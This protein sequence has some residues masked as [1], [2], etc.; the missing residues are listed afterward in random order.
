MHEREAKQTTRAFH[1]HKPGTASEPGGAAT[2]GV[3][4]VTLLLPGTAAG[5]PGLGVRLPKD[6]GSATGV[7]TAGVGVAATGL[8]TGVATTG[9]GGAATGLGTGVV[10]TGGVSGVAPDPVPG[11]RSNQPPARGIQGGERMRAGRRLREPSSRWHSCR[12]FAP[13]AAATRLTSLRG[14]ARRQHQQARQCQCA[15]ASATPPP[16]LLE[17]PHRVGCCL[18]AAA[19]G[20]GGE[21][22]TWQAEAGPGSA[23][24]RW[25][26]RQVLR[27]TTTPAGHG[28]TVGKERIYRCALAGARVRPSSPT[29]AMSQLPRKRRGSGAAGEARAGWWLGRPAHALLARDPAPVTGDE[30]LE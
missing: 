7:P 9:A 19:V 28:Y 26:P 10:V 22:G 15:A 5:A 16:L 25:Q 1:A 27:C 12:H 24:N 21:G 14:S 4:T 30:L 3:P 13:A 8:G 18:R 29:L 20:G 23:H 11:I 6:G 17:L 2:A